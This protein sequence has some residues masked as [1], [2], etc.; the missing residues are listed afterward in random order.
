MT[1]VREEKAAAYGDQVCQFVRHA[2]RR[3]KAGIRK[4]LTDHIA[5]HTQALIRAGHPPDTAQRLALAAMGEAEAVGRALDREYPLRWLVL[6]RLAPVAVVVFALV[7]L[8]HGW[9]VPYALR[10]YLDARGDP[11]QTQHTTIFDSSTG[12]SR[13]VP[14]LT[15]LDLRYQLPGGSVLSLY[16]VGLEPAGQAY[17]AYL[18]TVLYSQDPLPR[19]GVPREVLTFP[20]AE[21]Y[22]PMS[23]SNLGLA[24]YASYTISLS[25]GES[26]TARYD[27]YGIRIDAEIPLPWKEVLP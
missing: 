6:S 9:F 23:S 3:E 13:P 1:G 18:Y 26:L 14:N 21:T 8:Y 27:H 22:R 24:C 17:T 19:W 12:Q 7:L 20:S 5:D 16:A 11:I 15:P 10:D 25:P 4:E 2:T